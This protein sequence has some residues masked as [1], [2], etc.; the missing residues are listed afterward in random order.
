MTKYR[1]LYAKQFLHLQLYVYL[2]RA[3]IFVLSIAHAGACLAQLRFLIILI[4]LV[5]VTNVDTRAN[6][7]K[8]Y[9]ESLKI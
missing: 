4:D 5:H 3:G 8:V 1:P 6:E 7:V 9:F 2:V